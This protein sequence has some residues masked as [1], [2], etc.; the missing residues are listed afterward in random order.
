MGKEGCI[1]IEQVVVCLGSDFELLVKTRSLC[2]YSDSRHRGVKT[3]NKLY[4]WLITWHCFSSL[5]KCSQKAKFI[6]SISFNIS[7]FI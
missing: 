1:N 4:S 3:R 2:N 5:D 6:I 7:S